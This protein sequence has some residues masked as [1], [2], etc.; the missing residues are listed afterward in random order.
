MS[1][2]IKNLKKKYYAFSGILVAAAAVWTA[3]AMHTDGIL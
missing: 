3:A 2:Y 1:N